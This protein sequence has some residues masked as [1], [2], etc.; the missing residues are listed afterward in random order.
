MLGRTVGAGALAGGLLVAL[1]PPAVAGPQ[2]SDSV[3]LRDG[4][5]SVRVSW[6]MGCGTFREERR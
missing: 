3:T 2:T 5:S 4:S 6:S 1:A